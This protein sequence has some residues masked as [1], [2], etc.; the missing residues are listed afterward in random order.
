MSMQAIRDF[1]LKQRVRQAGGSMD[2]EI[3]CYYTRYDE[4]DGRVTVN[5]TEETEGCTRFKRPVLT[6]N[7]E[8]Q[9][10]ECE[11]STSVR[12]QVLDDAAEQYRE[13]RS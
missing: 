13:R 8:F 9:T 12:S 3:D 1:Q 10:C 2:I 11:Y 5:M 6:A 4:C 7:I